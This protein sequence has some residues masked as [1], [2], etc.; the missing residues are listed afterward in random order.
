MLRVDN[1]SELIKSKNR[2]KK[3]YAAL[4][5]IVKLSSLK[6]NITMAKDVKTTMK[7]VVS[8]SPCPT[9]S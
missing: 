8:W 9:V 2:K 4:Q 5:I 7:L 1:M 6:Q 3:I